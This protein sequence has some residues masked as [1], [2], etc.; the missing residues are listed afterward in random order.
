VVLCDLQGLARHGAAGQLRVPEGTLSSRLAR[1]RALL[2]DRLTRRG[3]APA[4]GAVA[5]ALSR[6]APAAVPEALAAMTVSAATRFAAGPVAAGAVSASV[7]SL[8]EGVLK[9]MFLSKLKMTTVVM[10]VGLA[11]TALALGQQSPEANQTASTSEPSRLR[12]VERKLDR[13]L[14]AL[15]AMNRGA[16]NEVEKT[17]P[18]TT[19]PETVVSQRQP[20]FTRHTPDKPSYPEPATPRNVPTTKSWS[21]DR[22]RD[23]ESRLDHVE[24]TLVELVDRVNRL[25]M[26]VR[27]TEKPS[28]TTARP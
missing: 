28:T 22:P 21:G 15:G 10:A 9:T 27:S 11:T 6:S 16:P 2:R 17:S 18:R 20:L 1:A 12:E 4:A 23:V 5:A 7:I 19:T 13:V 26:Q 8:S 14:E 3:L 24:R 25:E